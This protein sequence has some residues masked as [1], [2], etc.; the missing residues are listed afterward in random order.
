MSSRLY[1]FVPLWGIVV[2]FRYARHRVQCPIHGI[3]AE[4]IPWAEGKNHLTTTFKIYLA[5]WAQ[6][7]SWSTVASIFKVQ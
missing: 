6:H 5:Q 7:L 4:Y 3:V 1:Q 2:Y